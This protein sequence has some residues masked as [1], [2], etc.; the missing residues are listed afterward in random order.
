M[1]VNDVLKLIS[2]VHDYVDVV[3]FKWQNTIMEDSLPWFN[4]VSLLKMYSVYVA[5]W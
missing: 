2:D 3:W 4:A 1:A 5:F